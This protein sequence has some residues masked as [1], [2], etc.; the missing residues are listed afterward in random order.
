MNSNTRDIDDLSNALL[1]Q[2][3]Q[4]SLLE[5]DDCEP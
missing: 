2:G 5:T 4:S 1:Q 3:Q